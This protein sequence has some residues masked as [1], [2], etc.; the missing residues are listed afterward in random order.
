[1]LTSDGRGRGLPSGEGNLRASSSSDEPAIVRQIIFDVYGVPQ[2]KGSAKAFMPR[3]ARFPVVTNDNP[4]TKA[5]ER[6]IRDAAQPHAGTLLL[7]GVN[8][9]CCFELPRPK[10]LPK[11]V[12]Q[13]LKK[14]DIDKLARSVLD[15]L[16]G[17]LWRD[18]SQ[19]VSLTVTKQYAAPTNPACLHLL[20]READ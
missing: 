9:A 8:V 15:A 13:H 18:D 17:I 2:P 19:V 4:N 11:K 5:W 10:S 12:Q 16:T 20:I 1:M 3:G 7:G 6:A 14:P